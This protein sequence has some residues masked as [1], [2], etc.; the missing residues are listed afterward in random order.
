MDIRQAILKAADWIEKH[1]EDFMFSATQIPKCGTPGCA[2]WWIGH[3]SRMS[4]KTNDYESYTTVAKEVLRV[5]GEKLLGNGSPH[6]EFYRRM[7]ALL[8]HSGWMHYAPM[9][10]E[11]LRLYA[12][13]YHPA[14]IAVPNWEALSS[15]DKVPMREL[16]QG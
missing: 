1:P 15:P 5:P 6:F 10:A 4:L 11:G 12:D 13:K 9:C 7:D 16:V 2:L 3:F 14:P 8:G